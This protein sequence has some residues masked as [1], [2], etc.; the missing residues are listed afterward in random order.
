MSDQ[1][2]PDPGQEYPHE[3]VVQKQPQRKCPRV[4]SYPGPGQILLERMS[5]QEQ[6]RPECPGKCAVQ[7]VQ[8]PGLPQLVEFPK[9]R[10]PDDE[11]RVGT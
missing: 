4:L 2:R 3:E 10:P 8:V 1:H 5:D 6:R 11:S 7:P 9:V